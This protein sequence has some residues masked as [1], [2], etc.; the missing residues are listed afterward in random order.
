MIELWFDGYCENNPYGDCGI[1]VVIKQDGKDLHSISEHIGK[2]QGMSS[3]VAEYE[4]LR[5]GL[6]YLKDNNLQNEEIRFY[7]DSKMVIMQMSGKWKIKGGIYREKALEVKE[8]LKCF[9]NTVL[10]WIPREQN[11]KADELSSK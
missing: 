3:N 2:G 11:T 8:L 9:S 1:G 7:G 5:K 10:K 6:A 4:A